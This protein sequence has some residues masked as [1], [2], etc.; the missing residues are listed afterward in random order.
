MRIP[1]TSCQHG[2]PSLASGTATGEPHGA[3]PN[4]IGPWP[5]ARNATD[6][7]GA[8]LQSRRQ[9]SGIL[10]RDMKRTLPSRWRDPFGPGAP[11]D[12]LRHAACRPG[13]ITRVPPLAAKTLSLRNQ[14][15]SP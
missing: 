10:A 6:A 14:Q 2:R 4:R 9:P 3:W 7:A 11:A 13:T 1:R 15:G 12:R 5:D 8:G